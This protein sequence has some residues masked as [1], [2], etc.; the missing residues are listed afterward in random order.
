MNMKSKQIIYIKS[1]T[2][3]TDIYI[4]IAVLCV[5]ET[6][7]IK[8]KASNQFTSHNSYDSFNAKIFLSNKSC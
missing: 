8:S 1:I 6:A 5:D 3:S 4:A 7:L 2:V